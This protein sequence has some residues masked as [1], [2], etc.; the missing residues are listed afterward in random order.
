M[1]IG[2][3]MAWVRNGTTS[4]NPWKKVYIAKNRFDPAL[5]VWVTDWTL[6]ADLVVPPAAPP[7]VGIAK[8]PPTLITYGADVHWTVITDP[9]DD[10]YDWRV[11]AFFHNNTTADS[12]IIDAPQSQGS[13][14]SKAWAFGDNVNAD[15]FY[16]NTLAGA[17][18]PH[19]VTSSVI[20]GP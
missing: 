15:V 1:P 13:L 12:Y 17:D 10:R 19:A 4:W 9:S 3:N 18:G 11:V 5:L 6:V 14:R 20:L 8:A 7:G 2:V 16:T